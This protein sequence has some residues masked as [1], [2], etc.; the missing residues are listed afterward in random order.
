MPQWLRDACRPGAHIWVD[1]MAAS[2][3]AT[4]RSSNA[5]PR[6]ED[7]ATAASPIHGQCSPSGPP[8]AAAIGDTATCDRASAAHRHGGG[9]RRA[10]LADAIEAQ[11]A[12]R[13][14][15]L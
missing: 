10:L 3:A 9:P 8:A 12:A 11:H 7:W 4:T 13:R 5:W 2:T 6:R 1:E 14:L 15:G